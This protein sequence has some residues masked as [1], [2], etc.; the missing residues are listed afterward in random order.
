MSS[1]NLFCLPFAGGNKYSYRNYEKIAPDFINIIP[2]DL[3]GRGSRIRE[4][5]LTSMHDMVDDVL[6]QIKNK[7][8]QPYAIYGHSMGGWLT[9]LLTKKIVAERLTPPVALFITGCGGPSVEITERGRHLLPK[10]KFIDKLRELG[11]SPDEILQNPE[12]IEFFEPVLR[13]DFEAVDTYIHEDAEPLDIP[14]TVVIGLQE[15]A[16]YDEAMAWQKETTQPVTVRQFP[17]RHFFIY[18]FEEEIMKLIIKNL[19]SNILQL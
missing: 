17:G 6:M 3:P 9:Y 2:I 8:H 15:K 18:D 16:T 4:T 14:I 11:G 19:E 1:I 13:A 5:P 12:L 10:D 7:L